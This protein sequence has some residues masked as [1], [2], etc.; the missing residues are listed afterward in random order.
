M[1]EPEVVGDEEERASSRRSRVAA[2]L[3]LGA[4]LTART[5]PMQDQGRP[6]SSLQ[7]RVGHQVL[8]LAKE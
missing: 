1:S 6:E 2:H 8:P 5:S 4:I 3:N 7:R